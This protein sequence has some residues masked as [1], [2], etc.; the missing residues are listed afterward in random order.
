[1]KYGQKKYK[2]YKE[3]FNIN[4]MTH[5]IAQILKISPEEY[6]D[7][8]F[9][10]WF[11]YCIVR[12]HKT[13]TDLQKLIANT[14]LNKWWHDQFNLLETEFYEEISD[15]IEVLDKKNAMELYKKV[16]LNIFMF[17]SPGILKEARKTT[18]IN[19]PTYN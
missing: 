16:V 15:F 17:S 13:K 7:I 8:I 5:T 9:D 10:L 3:Q 6:E 4:I 14:A 1:M 11:R 18:I 12:S 19:K 2:N